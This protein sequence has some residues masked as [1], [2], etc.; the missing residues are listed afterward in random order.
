MGANSVKQQQEEKKNIFKT[1]E[2]VVRLDKIFE[3]GLPVKYLP[4]ILYVS[5]FLIFYIGNTHYAERTVRTIDK[6]KA[7]VD[8]MRADYT[9][10]KAELMYA[11]KQSEV[12][13]KVN[14]IGL[15]ESL[16][17]PNKIIIEEGEY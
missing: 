3:E 2:S 12:A 11:T 4:Y 7:E 8:D 16:V 5:C 14:I 1:M 17:P 9:T 10:L 15:E 13:K 6:V